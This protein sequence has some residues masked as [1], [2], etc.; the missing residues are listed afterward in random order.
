MSAEKAGEIGNGVISSF[1]LTPIEL[2]GLTGITKISAGGWFSLALRS[3]GPSGP[4]VYNDDGELAAAFVD[5]RGRRWR[6]AS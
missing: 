1:Q 4:G 5:A 6:T 2:T 3:D